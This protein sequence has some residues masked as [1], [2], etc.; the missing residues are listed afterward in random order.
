VPA[1][2]RRLGRQALLETGP[3]LRRYRT[4]PPALPVALTPLPTWIR[5]LAPSGP[6][7]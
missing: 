1:D 4:H 3:K 2:R 7:T 6:T 5:A